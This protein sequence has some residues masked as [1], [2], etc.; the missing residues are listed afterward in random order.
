MFGQINR[1]T[2]VAG[3]RDEVVQLVLSGSDN[4]PG[5]RSY[6]V[7]RDA[8]NADIIWVT[9]VWNSADMHKASMHI[10]EVEASVEK[11]MPMIAGFETVAT[12]IP[13]TRA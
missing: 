8:D 7:A 12:I 11:A 2:T 9:E 6:L 5:C 1:I 4:M 10:P 13:A 3:K